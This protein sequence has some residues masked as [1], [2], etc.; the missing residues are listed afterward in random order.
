MSKVVDFGHGFTQKLLSNNDGNYAVETQF[1]DDHFRKVSDRIRSSGMLNK[2]KLGL[3]DDED[4]RFVISFPSTMAFSNFKR[5][6]SVT[7][8]LLKST[9]EAERVKGG[10]QL[11]LLHPDWVLE[12]RA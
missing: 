1:H 9:D 11:Q 6:H 4:V 10:L 3:H 8:S 5:N 2:M 7:Y 12:A